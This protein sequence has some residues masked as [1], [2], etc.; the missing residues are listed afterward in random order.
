LRT[1]NPLPKPPATLLL[2]WFYLGILACIN[3][4][5]C[6]DAFATESTGHWNS[7]HG[8]WISLARIA[9]FDWV[10]PTWW[11]YWGGGAPLEFT[12]APLVPVA[13]ASMM[14]L[15]HCSAAFALNLL[16][17]LVYCLGPVTFYLLS[18]KLSGRAGY[19]FAAALAWSL[20]SPAA[21]LIPDH[22]FQLSSLWS[23]R[24]LYLA[25]EWDD[26][27]HLTSLMLLPLAAWPLT[28]ALQRGRPT[29]YAL[30]ILAMAGM[31]LANMFGAV[32]A[33]LL[34]ITA[35][36]ALDY[37][38]R[39][40]MLARA[41]MA[42]AAAYVVASPWVPPSLLMTIRANEAANGEGGWSVGS[43]VAFGIVAFCWWAVRRASAGYAREWPARWMLQFG[44]VVILIP[45]L[46]QYGLHFLPQPGRYKVEAELAM[47][48]IA[49]FAL[50]PWMER[51]AGWLRVAL[52]VALLL[53]AARQTLLI[54]RFAGGL[55]HPVDVQRSIE[56]RSAKWVE[57][58]LPGERVMMAGS[59]GNFLNAFTR[60]PQLSA[61]PYT[62][63]PNWEEQIAVYTIYLG[64][65]A[66]ER[67]GEYS[68]LWLKAF[69]AEAVAVPGPRSPEYWKP[70]TRPRKF[71][72]MLPVLWR[73]EDTTIYRVPRR[74]GSLA[75]VLRPDQVVL[76][77]PIHGL[78]TMEVSRFVTAL[79][80]DSKPAQ[81]EWRGSNRARIRAVLAPGEIVSTQIN[82]HPGWH[83]AVKGGIATVRPDGI[84]L[85]EVE[86][87]CTGDCEMTLEYDGGGELRVCR[88]A[89]GGVLLVL[90]AAGWL[91][92][93][94]VRERPRAH[95][96]SC[97]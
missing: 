84:G 3:V 37:P 97:G 40:S 94:H 83:A 30:S 74:S 90:L 14:R 2:P 7:I 68:L 50:R 95:A 87:N 44:C 10:R 59:L 89:S 45:A 85:M 12:Y 66:G 32:L 43:T 69:G 82:Y 64:E 6:R 72:G 60:T 57:E 96:V 86:P 33:G 42:I 18:W 77:R 41:A 38:L 71:D 52:V 91:Q 67:D 39:F 53:A 20:I 23:A 26:L 4:Y 17:G 88:A 19:S 73:E 51:A 11:P 21:L 31:M 16:T 48:W 24:R 34:A 22:G 81:L 62:T 61:Q 55:M 36:L 78:D 5:I 28:R 75:H 76:H 13:M 49:V 93:R 47:V 29:D 70:F 1:R 35:A 8:Q 63:A 79:E 80:S 25:F 15:F 54:G 56:Y 46:G 65:N 58:N 92:R 27:P 9:G